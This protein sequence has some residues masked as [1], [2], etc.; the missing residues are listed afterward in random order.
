MYIGGDLSTKGR[1]LSTEGQT[2]L[3]SGGLVY[4]VGGSS[5]Q[6]NCLTVAIISETYI[7]NEYI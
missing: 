1:D 6:I 5:T 7:T 4:G 3:L 2:R